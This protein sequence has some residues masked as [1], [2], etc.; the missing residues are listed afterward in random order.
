MRKGMAPLLRRTG[1]DDRA[2]ERLYRRHVTDVFR[3][4]LAVLGDR[5]DAEDVTQTTFLNAYRAFQRGERPEKAQNWL[6]TIAHNVCRQRFRQEA[7]RPSEV[8]YADEIGRAVEEATG[9]TAEDLK[10]AFSY[11]PPNQRAAL[12]MRE[13]EGRSYAE[14]A[15]VLEIS[16]SALETLL[17]RARRTLREQ[18]EEQLTCHEAELAVSRQMDGRLPARERGALRA[19]LRACPECAALAH[20]Q[21]AQRRALRTLLAV[22][23]PPGLGSFFGGHAAEA[24]VGT[25]AAAGGTSVAVKAVAVVCGAALVGGGTYEGVKHVPSLANKKTPARAVTQPAAARPVVDSVA[26]ASIESPMR[27]SIAAD[28]REI[29]GED[30]SG[31]GPGAAERGHDSGRSTQAGREHGRPTDAVRA[32]GEPRGRL[33]QQLSDG[34]RGQGSV[35]SSDRSRHASGRGARTTEAVPAASARKGAGRGKPEVGGSARAGKPG[36]E[37]RSG[38]RGPRKQNPAAGET[39]AVAPALPPVETTPLPEPSRPDGRGGGR[40]R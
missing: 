31:R 9:P 14:I 33:K 25:V 22:P 19:H 18:L 30:H 38:N 34:Q 20:S 16:V 35:R 6:I 7:R 12:V 8:E 5:S 1:T 36:N 10:R 29:R 4:S 24:A 2:F 32:G 21:R 13:L 40:P 23:L 15:A 3:Y 26:A 17:F 28:A 39:V 11:L 37:P 27:R